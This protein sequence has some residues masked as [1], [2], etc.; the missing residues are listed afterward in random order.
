MALAS[1]FGS[2]KE[3]G[4]TALDILHTRFELLVTEFSEEQSRLAELLLLAA[5]ASSCLF[6]AAALVA[7]F[8]VASL[9]DTPY[10]LIAA[11][12]L[13]AVLLGG[14]AACSVTF[15]RRAHARPR[16]FSTSLG[17]LGADLERLQ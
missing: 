4:R 17:E 8:V 3:I 7:A 2:L 14:A 6:L 10:R 12:A 13:V 16:P 9:W 11:G 5:V 1:P 15:L